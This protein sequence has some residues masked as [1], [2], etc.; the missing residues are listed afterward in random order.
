MK[1]LT[2]HN[3]GDMEAP[4]YYYY[5]GNPIYLS[6]VDDKILV[7]F[8]QPLTRAQQKNLLGTINKN[9]SLNVDKTLN[10]IPEDYQLKYVV[11]YLSNEQNLRTAASSLNDTLIQMDEVAFVSPFFIS[12][13]QQSENTK[14]SIALT[15]QLLVQPLIKV[16]IEDFK[17]IFD[18]IGV[19]SYELFDAIQNTYL[20]V[21]RDDSGYTSVEASNELFE[22]GKFGF[23]TPDFFRMAVGQSY[24]P[25]DPDYPN[26]YF[27]PRIAANDAWCWTKGENIKIAV[28]DV[29]IQADHPDLAANMLPGYDP[30]GQPFGYD[31]H[32]TWVAGVAA[33]KGDNA[34]GIAGTAFNAKIIPIRIG[35][36]P[37]NDPNSDVFLASDSNIVNCINQAWN[38]L[39]ADILINSFGLG[40]PSS[41]VDSAYNSAMGSGRS[42]KGCIVVA[43]TGNEN[44][45]NVGYP[46]RLTNV[47]AIGASSPY[48]ARAY[49]SNYGNDLDFVA[50]G[51]SIRTTA[52]GSTYS[53]SD[54]TSFSCPMV[55]GVAALLLSVNPDLT[56][57]NLYRLLVTSCDKVGGYTYG[58]IK[59]YDTWNNE[60]GYG[61]IN[62]FRAVSAVLQGIYSINGPNY[63]CVGNQGTF[64]VSGL[65]AGATVA[66]SAASGVTI[67]ASSG[68]ATAQSAGEGQRVPIYAQI[69]NNC[70][71]FNISLTK[72]L[73]IGAVQ[74][75]CF[76]NAII[77]NPYRMSWAAAYNGSFYLKNNNNQSGAS[78]YIYFGYAPSIGQTTSN[79]PAYGVTWGTQGISAIS[80][81]NQPLGWTGTYISGNSLSVYCNNASGVLEINL[82]TPCG[83][84]FCRFYISGI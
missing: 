84:A 74:A 27:I 67:D 25:N 38:N 44:S 26:E 78:N 6:M 29:A 35:Y 46:A 77:S 49:F 79:P 83:L 51:E 14:L 37:T 70:S 28:L 21:L 64:S 23:A 71:S 61:R 65:Q 15:N 1:T 5:N 56:R 7:G 2:H 66:W 20:L 48:D 73:P 80:I 62:A 60:M 75:E 69:S 22:T 11:V 72:N 52:V 41:A 47:I 13:D 31:R 17:D 55:A 33:A 50:P 57:D 59:P 43:S 42:N 36:K 82:Q 4:F 19:A 16:P 30:T 76:G 32:G 9:S 63:L 45:T 54:G 12:N 34:I 18:K 53:Y 68:V 40:S 58:N 81:V 10:G 39:G 24:T 8:K 3:E